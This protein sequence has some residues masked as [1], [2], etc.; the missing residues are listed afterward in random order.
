MIWRYV[1]TNELIDNNRRCAKCNC[2]PTKEGYDACLGYL[3]GASSACCGHGKVPAY[4]VY[5]EQSVK[6]EI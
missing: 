5:E 1:D 6:E 3:K 2:L 4:I